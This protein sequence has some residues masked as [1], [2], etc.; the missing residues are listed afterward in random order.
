MDDAE[1]NV[2]CGIFKLD[3]LEEYLKISSENGCKI[4]F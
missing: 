2:Q 1:G 4:F 3:F